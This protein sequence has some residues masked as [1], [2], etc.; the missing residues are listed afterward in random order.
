MSADSPQMTIIPKQPSQD[1]QMSVRRSTEA[2]QRC[3]MASLKSVAVTSEIG[4]VAIDD[5]PYGTWSLSCM[6]GVP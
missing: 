6:L 4:R 2:Q 1:P 5:R 3:H